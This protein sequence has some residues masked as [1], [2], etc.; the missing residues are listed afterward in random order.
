[1]RQDSSGWKANLLLQV[2]FRCAAEISLSSPGTNRSEIVLRRIVPPAVAV[3]AQDDGEHLR[4][5]SGR[6]TRRQSKHQEESEAGKKSA[7]RIPH[8][9]GKTHNGKKQ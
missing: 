3:T 8:A 4:I 6:P 7:E 9:D 1:M 2:R 5:T